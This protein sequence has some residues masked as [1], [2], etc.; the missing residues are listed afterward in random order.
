LS[1]D[2]TPT[3][4]DLPGPAGDAAQP[5]PWALARQASELLDRRRMLQARQLLA[6]AL[7]QHP[8]AI[9][10]LFQLARADYLEDHFEDARRTLVRL[11]ELAPGDTGGRW[12]LFLVE[13]E[14]G[15]LAEAEVLVLDLLRQSPRMPHFWS[16]YGRL[17]LRA[18][19]FDKAS[20]LVN[21]ALR[22]DPDAPE[23]LRARALCDI[24]EGRG[25]QDGAALS[26]LLADDPNDLL[27]LRLVVVALADAGRYRQAHRLAQ[28]L[29]RV[30]PD[31]QGLLQ[32]VLALHTT[33]HWSL[34]PLWP[35]R[36]WGWAAS[37]GLWV[38]VVLGYQVLERVAPQAVGGFTAVVLA[39]VAYSWV[40]P[41]LLTRWIARGA[42]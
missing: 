26:R 10:L 25:Q 2:H 21:E 24:V 3:A 22:L 18:L 1:H 39:Y 23:A 7:R 8:E 29:L 30:Q 17:M 41:P 14:A 4:P 37:V 34:W 15:R 19:H 11:L 40:W 28:A 42:D 16:G 32:Q 31:D 36:R 5:S 13:M 38:L 35:L 9:E 33:N 20:D 27:T 12:L 6:Q